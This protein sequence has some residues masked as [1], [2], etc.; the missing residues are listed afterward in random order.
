MTT[1][2]PVPKL[3]PDTTLTVVFPEMPPTF[4]DVIQKRNEK[5]QMT[6]FLPSNYDPAKRGKLERPEPGS[7]TDPVACSGTR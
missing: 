5:A 4:Y 7:T 3:A 2:E 1:A 6:V